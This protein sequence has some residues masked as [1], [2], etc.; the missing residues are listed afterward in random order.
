MLEPIFERDVQSNSFRFRLKRIENQALTEYLVY[1]N[2]G[3]QHIVYIDLKSFFDEVD[4]DILLSF[5]YKKVRC[6]YM[7][8]LI[9]QFLRASIQTKLKSLM[10]G[11]AIVCITAYGII[12]RS[13]SVRG[14]TSYS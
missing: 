13:Q 10:T 1:I 2:E 11:Y 14:I 4:H 12:G 9:L 6:V 3:N 7:M 5:I 8:K